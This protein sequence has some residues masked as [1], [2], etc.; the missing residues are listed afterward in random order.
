[1]RILR[2]LKIIGKSR[3]FANVKNGFLKLVKI[4]IRVRAATENQ[5]AIN[6]VDMS[7]FTGAP[8]L[9]PSPGDEI[10]PRT[11]LG[12]CLRPQINSPPRIAIA[13]VT[14]PPYPMYATACN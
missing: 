8:P 11:L 13:M 2:N 1:M 3:I 6:A 9:T 12:L 5:T 14:L 7:S 4:H 10:C